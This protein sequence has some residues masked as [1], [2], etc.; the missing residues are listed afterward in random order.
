MYILVNQIVQE[1][2]YFWLI[3]ELLQLKEEKKCFS[4]FF[5]FSVSVEG[6]LTAD[7]DDAGGAEQLE[8]HRVGFVR[9]CV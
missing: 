2:L 4:S 7:F 6:I 5:L 9:V 3:N 1:S 8:V